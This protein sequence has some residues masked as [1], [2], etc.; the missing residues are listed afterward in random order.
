MME[1]LRAKVIEFYVSEFWPTRSN[2]L[3]PKEGGKLIEF[4]SPKRKSG[5]LTH[6]HWPAIYGLCCTIRCKSSSGRTG[7]TTCA[8]HEK[9]WA[10]PARNFGQI[11]RLIRPVRSHLRL[12]RRGR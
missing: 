1:G 12:L 10:I 6:A 7:D 11:G 3:A 5:K 2:Y 9:R 4:R 8:M